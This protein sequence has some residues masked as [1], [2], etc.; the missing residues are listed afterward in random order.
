MHPTSRRFPR[1]TT[2]GIVAPTA[3]LLADP[4][5]VAILWALADGRTRPASELAAIARVAR[6]TASEHLALLVMG[7]LLDMEARGRSRFYCIRDAH[8]VHALEA[9]AAV[10]PAP[11]S[12]PCSI[13][14]GLALAR[15]CYDH[16]AGRLSLQ[17][18]ESLVDRSGLQRVADHFELGPN[19]AV[20]LGRMGVDLDATIAEATLRRRP[21]LRACLDWS[22]RRPHLAGALGS[23][24]LS[25]LLGRRWL[26]RTGGSRALQVTRKGRTAL[27]GLGIDAYAL[28]QDL[29]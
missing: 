1:D 11:V 26:D 6:S 14:S 16:L 17:L 4:S 9:L 25:S 2:E 20:V 22:E 21:L 12:R 24:L 7:G 18:V 23:A 3:K 5:R 13:P 10:G 15:S 28:P 29:A 19:A 8:V 27:R